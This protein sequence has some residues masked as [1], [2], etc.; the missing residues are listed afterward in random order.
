MPPGVA[1]RNYQRIIKGGHTSL[2]KKR[3][4]CTLQNNFKLQIKN[5]ENS[6]TI[7]PNE[8]SMSIP[9]IFE[10]AKKNGYKVEMAA[11]GKHIVFH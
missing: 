2:G 9:E 1:V 6:A 5:E 11:D 7:D 10:E 4:S 8:Y 3:V